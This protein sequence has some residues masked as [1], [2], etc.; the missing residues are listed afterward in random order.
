MGVGSVGEQTIV[1]YFIDCVDTI[2]EYL[3]FDAV[4]F[5]TDDYGFKFHSET[6]GK[7]ATF[8]EEFEAYVSHFAF[9]VFAV[10]Y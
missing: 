1:L 10:Y 7:H 4:E 8:C 3:I 5:A 6:V 2:G 9:V